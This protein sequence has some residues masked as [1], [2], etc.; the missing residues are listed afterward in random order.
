M[1]ARRE[2]GLGGGIIDPATQTDRPTTRAGASS[3][4]ENG[5][6]MPVE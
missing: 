2:A 1:A 6:A 3:G 5:H 4:G